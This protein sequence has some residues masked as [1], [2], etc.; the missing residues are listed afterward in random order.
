MQLAIILHIDLYIYFNP[1]MF[2]LGL[3][4]YTT[5]GHLASDWMAIKNSP[6][7]RVVIVADEGI[8]S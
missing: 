8:S 1:Q 3:Q 6:H 7:T 5:L 4:I 2:I